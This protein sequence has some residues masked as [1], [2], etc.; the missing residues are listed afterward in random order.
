MVIEKEINPV[1]SLYFLGAEILSELLANQTMD[2]IDLYKRIK[3][4][5][6]ISIKL[7]ILALDF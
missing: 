1:Y 6:N 4:S 3:S 2:F 5:Y 7:F